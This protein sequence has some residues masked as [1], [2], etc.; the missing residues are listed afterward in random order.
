MKWIDANKELPV[1]YLVSVFIKATWYRKE[2]KTVG[3]Y[4][5]SNK[6]FHTRGGGIFSRK[7]VKWLK[8]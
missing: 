3:F 6:K 4:N 2:I 7:N 8:E 5:P 1:G